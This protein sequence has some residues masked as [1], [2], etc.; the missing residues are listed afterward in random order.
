MTQWRRRRL[1]T[2]L[3][4]AALLAPGAAA[5][6]PSQTDSPVER[7][8][9]APAAAADS[10]VVAQAQGGEGGE[11]SEGGE[12]GEGGVDPARAAEDPVTYLIALDIIRAHYLAGLGAYAAGN[13]QAAAEMFVHPIAEVY[14]TLEPVLEARDVP[15]FVDAM[16]EAGDLAFAGADLADIRDAAEA[17]LAATEEA[18]RHAPESARARA[19]VE[20]AVVADMVD[21]AARQYAFAKSQDMPG[22]YLDGYGYFK[23]AARRA[24]ATRAAIRDRDEKAW[25]RIE[26]ALEALEAAYPEAEP[27]E[28]LDRDPGALLSAASRAVLA[29]G[30]L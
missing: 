25:A 7:A 11:G 3:S 5:A 23:A 18:A 4:A 19:A 6:T 9:A 15:P 21:R 1:W 29:T 13:R 22:A 24:D 30:A 10:I 16:T 14:Y 28:S 26:A 12:G 20:A 2:S 17:V 27:P 8:A